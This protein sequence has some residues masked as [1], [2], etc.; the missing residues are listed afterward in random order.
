MLTVGSLIVFGALGLARFGYGMVLPSM[1]AALNLTNTQTGLLAT[2][3]LLGY[4]AIG[5]CRCHR[6]ALW[7]LDCGHHRPPS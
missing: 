3:N 1:Q 4:M 7:L 5:H 6:L 2:A